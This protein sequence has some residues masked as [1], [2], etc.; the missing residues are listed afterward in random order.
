M[1]QNPE[2]IFACKYEQLQYASYQHLDVLQEI[3]QEL[4]SVLAQAPDNV[5]GLIALLKNQQMQGRGEKAR[6][7]AHKIWSIGGDISPYQE[8]CYI[9]LLLSLGMLDMALTLLQPRLSNLSD[10]VEVFASVMIRFALLTGNLPLLAQITATANDGSEQ[11]FAEFI[12]AY[13]ELEYAEHFRNIQRLIAD[14]LRNHRLGFDYQLYFDRGFTDLSVT[15]YTDVPVGAC[16]SA[17]KD[18]N[19]KIDDYHTS[20]NIKRIYNYEVKIKNISE[21]PSDIS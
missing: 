12:N 4:Y 15:Y 2:Y 5:A 17:T 1:E 19:Q 14:T 13:Q 21:S 3:E 8:Y 18:L 6:Q 9:N 10:N 20:A 11:L 7:L 16:A